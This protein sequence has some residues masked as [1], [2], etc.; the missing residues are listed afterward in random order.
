MR[1]N[2]MPLLFAV[3]FLAV[4]SYCTEE[5]TNPVE[6]KQGTPDV[7][8]HC[9]DTVELHSPKAGEVYTVG[10]TLEIR[11]CSDTAYPTLVAITFDGESLWHNLGHCCPLTSFDTTAWSPEPG[12]I[13]WPIPSAAV[14]PEYGDT[15][16]TVSQ[17]CR[18]V[19]H[20]LRDTNVKAYS[21]GYFTI[22]AKEQ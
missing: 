17:A 1:K 14:D 11:F 22:R 8:Y 15:L 6:K 9:A 4:F 5:G 18:V 13:R 21:E 16:T 7:S 12:V 10:D 19:A 2:S 3:A 20:R